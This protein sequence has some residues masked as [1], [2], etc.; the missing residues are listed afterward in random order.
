MKK[1]LYL[2]LMMLMVSPALADNTRHRGSHN[3]RRSAR[4]RRIGHSSSHTRRTVRSNRRSRAERSR[5]CHTRSYRSRSNYRYHRHTNQRSYRV[6][7]VAVRPRVV[8]KRPK[9]RRTQPVPQRHK[10]IMIVGG[11]NNQSLGSRSVRRDK[12]IAESKQKVSK[13][14]YKKTER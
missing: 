6:I 10:T 1:M 14:V 7:Y 4:R 12:I 11:N 9:T 13:D 2:L 5:V 8:K 3:T